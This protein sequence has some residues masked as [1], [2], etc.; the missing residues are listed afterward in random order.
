[1]RSSRSEPRLINGSILADKIGADRARVSFSEKQKSRQKL[2][3]TRQRSR[4][5]IEQRD[6]S[7][8]AIAA[9]RP[10]DRE[11]SLE[12]RT[13]ARLNRSSLSLSFSLMLFQN[14]LF[15]SENSHAKAARVATRI[16]RRDTS[17]LM[18][19]R[20]SAFRASRGQTSGTLW[21]RKR[22]TLR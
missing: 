8:D 16:E 10:R 19:P 18:I 12:S 9:S 11:I 1:M 6:R 3:Q 5:C 22:R 14:G 17:R 4:R 7:R 21:Q 20:S 15:T 2:L 13:L